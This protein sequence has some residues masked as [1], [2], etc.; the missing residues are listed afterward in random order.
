MIYLVV[1]AG[2]S[3]IEYVLDMFPF[4]FPFGF[5]K[6]ARMGGLNIRDDWMTG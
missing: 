5:P 6:F 4:E 2:L 3:Q 1:G